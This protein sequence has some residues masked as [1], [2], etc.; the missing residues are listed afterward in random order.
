M[1]QRAIYIGFGGYQVSVHSDVSEVI[2]M[3]ERGFRE[4][5]VCQPTRIVGRLEVYRDGG[6]YKVWGC[7][8]SDGEFK[9]ASQVLRGLCNEITIIFI[10]TLSTHL[11]FHAGAAAQRGSAVVILGPGGRGKSTLVTRLCANG[12]TYLSDDTIAVDPISDRAFPFPVTPA[13]R[14]DQGC[15][16]PLERLRTIRKTDVD[17]ISAAVCREA[18]PIGALVFPVYSLSSPSKLSRCSPATAALELLGNCLN[19]TSHREAAVYYLCDL[20][21]RLPAFRLTYSSGGLAAEL[22][23]RS[24]GDWCGIYRSGSGVSGENRSD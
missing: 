11:W 9:S 8:E 20:A 16:V 4:M 10:K 19:F 13:V 18:M 15:E 7:S 5:L 14:E 12:W 24:H 1:D 6:K 21:M 2:A 3:L 22:I 23:A 17:L